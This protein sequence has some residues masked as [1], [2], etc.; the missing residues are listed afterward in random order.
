[1]EKRRLA[2]VYLFALYGRLPFGG[3]S[4]VSVRIAQCLR[5]PDNKVLAGSLTKG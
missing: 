2:S 1:M 4:S 5:S 3:M